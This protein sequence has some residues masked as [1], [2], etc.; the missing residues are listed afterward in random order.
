MFCNKRGRTV[1]RKSLDF[2]LEH[3]GLCTI[4]RILSL[5]NDICRYKR[6]SSLQRNT[7]HM[8]MNIGVA[9]KL[10][11]LCSCKILKLDTNRFFH[12]LARIYSTAVFF[13]IL[14]GIFFRGFYI[15]SPCHI[16]VDTLC[17]A[18][19]VETD[20]DRGRQLKMCSGYR[21]VVIILAC[22]KILAIL[23]CH[24]SI[25]FLLSG[26]R[27]ILVIALNIEHTHEIGIAWILFKNLFL[28]SG[29]NKVSSYGINDFLPDL[30][31]LKS[32]SHYASSF[33]A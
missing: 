5:V 11:I 2:H 20:T 32:V 14:T 16:Q 6:I 31:I 25:N 9:D 26:A 18:L 28:F 22:R 23:K 27:V 30:R 4:G 33:T 7:G 17:I 29:T 24:I 19:D 12:R 1:L 3:N 10:V 15:V 21:L 8:N 13:F